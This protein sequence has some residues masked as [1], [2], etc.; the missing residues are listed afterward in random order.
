MKN[1][2]SL[3]VSDMIR[4]G[5]SVHLVNQQFLEV[6][7]VA[8]NGYFSDHPDLEFWCAV[9][10]P[11]KDWMEIYV[12]EYCHFLQ[13]K[14]QTDKWKATSVKNGSTENL[15]DEWISG[16]PIKQ[17]LV[18]MYAKANRDVEEE[19]ERMVVQNIR[20]Y[21]LP[22]NIKNYVKKANAYLYFWSALP[23]IRKWPTGGK[24]PYTIPEIVNSMPIKFQRD[25]DKI[26]DS[27][28]K[29]LE[30]HCYV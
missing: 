22:I 16:K 14:K 8:C 29:L 12:H 1:F 5:V 19:C 28:I 6:E 26:P 21:Q 4:K 3:S 18:Y 23:Y 25:Y 13:W 11:R 15:I 20:K 24:G 10:K 9:K 30:E 7:D 17:D 2:I 27:Y